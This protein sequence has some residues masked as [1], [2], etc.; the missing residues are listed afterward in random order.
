MSKDLALGNMDVPLSLI[1]IDASV[2]HFLL[3]ETL[4][5]ESYLS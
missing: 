3:S 5:Q 2:K 1:P 4:L